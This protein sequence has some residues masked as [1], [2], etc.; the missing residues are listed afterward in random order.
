[1]TYLRRLRFFH[2]LSLL[3]VLALLVACAAP[4]AAPGAAPAAEAGEAAEAPAEEAATGDL[5]AEPGR[6]T[7]GTLNI[8]YWQAVSIVNPYLS[9]GTKDYLAG[10]FVLEPLIEYNQAGELRPVLVEEIPTLEN[11]GISEDLTSVTY[12]LLEGVLWSDGTPLTA[13]DVVF[14]WQYCADESTGCSSGPS[15]DGVEVVEALDERTVRI[16]FSQPTPYPYNP[17][18]GYLAPVLQQAQFADCLG[19]AAQTCAEQNTFP[20]GTGPY[21]VSE[22]LANDTVVYTIN[23]NYRVPDKPHFAQVVIKGGGDAPSAAR[24]VLETSEADYAWNVQVEPDILNAMA[25]AGLGSVSAG[26]AANVERIVINFTNPDPAL[27]ELRSEWTMDDP[28]PHPFLSD[29]VVRQALSMAIDRT[30]I[31]DQLY[32]AAGKPTCNILSGPPAMVSTANDACLTQDIEGAI[33]LLE[34]AGWVDS[35]GDGVREKDGVELRIL[36]QTSTN[37]VRQ[38][39]Q[40]LVQQWWQEIGV[41]TEL[42]NIEAA[43]FF[44]ADPASPD[45]LSK[46]YADVQMYTNGPSS[47]DPQNFLAEWRCNDGAN[48]A[49]SA[50]TW[51]G[52]NVNRWCSPEYD[53]LHDQLIAA[54]DPAEREE[55]AKQL[56]DM[57]VQN[58]VILPLVFRSSPSAVSNT[59]DIGGDVNGWDSEHWNIEDWFRVR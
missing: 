53:A 47:P 12:T 37:A 6:G 26:F 21:K 33:A 14:T 4:A 45:T 20:I 55:L 17:F 8:L 10:S 27:G 42:K 56:N 48:I 9:T 51:L 59:L 38:K 43:V 40:A 22:F 23:E 7:D 31:S 52:N 13:N 2:L 57:L 50:N 39:T 36:Y 30:I 49:S 3:G 41:A 29:P 54:S 5:P 15:F 24:A 28:N 35:N 1:M 58:N 44:G 25:E 11:G 34:G 32:G 16:T 18:G 19:A 46:F